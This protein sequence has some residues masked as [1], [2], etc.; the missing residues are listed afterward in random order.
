[1]KYLGEIIL[2]ST[3]NDHLSSFA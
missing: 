1:V 3:H 2:Y